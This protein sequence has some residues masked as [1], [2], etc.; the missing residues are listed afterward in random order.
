MAN[1]SIYLMVQPRLP[2]LEEDRF[3]AGQ[4]GPYAKYPL[5]SVLTCRNMSYG[6]ENCWFNH[7]DRINTY[8][9]ENNGKLNGNEEIVEWKLLK[10]NVMEII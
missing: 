1:D 4:Q 7:G 2:S 9:N 6:I 5:D 3:P 10:K 8:K